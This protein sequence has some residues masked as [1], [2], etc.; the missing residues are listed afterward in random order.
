MARTYGKQNYTKSQAADAYAEDYAGS[1]PWR[2]SG[3]N[4]E[5]RRDGKWIA[6]RSKDSC[7]SEWDR[8]NP[9]DNAIK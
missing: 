4:L 1:E 7:A 5:V 9:K 8:M 2:W 6:I 3:G